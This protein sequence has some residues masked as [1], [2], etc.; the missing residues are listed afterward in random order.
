MTSRSN[1]VKRANVSSTGYW[2]ARRCKRAVPK[3][4]LRKLG[5]VHVG[6]HFNQL[7]SG[8]DVLK[9]KSSVTYTNVW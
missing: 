4:M 9:D 2:S 1:A 6:A 3:V 7:A 8:S 5:G